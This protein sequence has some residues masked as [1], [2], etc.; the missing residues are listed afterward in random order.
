MAALG[1]SDTGPHHQDSNLVSH[2]S[3]LWNTSLWEETLKTGIQIEYK[4]RK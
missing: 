4:T 3:A 1:N 2:Q